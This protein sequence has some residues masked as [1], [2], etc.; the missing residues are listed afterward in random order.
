[1]ALFTED[2]LKKYA[3]AAV[4]ENGRK[5]F[6]RGK[7]TNLNFVGN[8]IIAQ[9]KADKPLKVVISRDESDLR[10]CCN[11][12]FSY[13]GACEHVVASMLAANEN[14]AIQIGINWDALPLEECDSTNE[15]NTPQCVN[16]DEYDNSADIDP[17]ENSG[18]DVEDIEPGKP[19]ARIYLTECDLML[20]AELRFAY[21]DGTVEFT[22]SDNNPV[23]M[24]AQQDG[25]IYRIHRSKVR[26]MTVVSRMHEFELVQ[27]QTGFF[28]PECDPRIWTLHELPRLA[29]EGFEIYGQDN[30]KTS[31]ARK[32]VP[33]LS[34]SIKSDSSG[35]DCSVEISYDG[36][37]AT[38]ASIIKAIRDGSKFVLLSDGTSG[39]LPQEW[40]DKFTSL[41]AAFDADPEEKS[42]KVKTSHVALAGML[43]DMA[44]I[45]KGDSE[46]I[47]KRGLFETFKGV[48]KCSLPKDF[49]ASMRP[50]QLAGYEWFY[51][52]KKFNF[53]GCLADDMGLGKTVQ[54]LA[55]LQKEKE[56]CAQ[57]P[58]LV[59]VPTSLLFNWQREAEKFAP[60]LQILCLHGASRNRYYDVAEM[61]DVILTSYGTVLRDIDILSKKQFHYIILDEAQVIKNPASRISR[62][63]RHL[64]S[65][66]R[67]A[68]SGTPI[69]NNLSEL[70]SLFS[71]LNPGML[72]TF[73]NFATNFIKP[74]EKEMNENA[75]EVL[76]RL[77]FPYILRRTKQQVA[78][79]LPPKNEIVLYAEML[80]KQK[81]V[82]DITREIFLG[83]IESSFQNEDSEKTRFKILEG[84]LR[85]RQIC[86]HPQM[87]DPSFSGDSGKFK[88]IE[89]SII[90]VTSGGHR[91]LVFSQFVK[92]LEI[93]KLRIAEK[94]IHSEILTGATS[95]R[96]AVVDRF[97]KKDG[98][99]VFFISLKAGGTGL[100]LTAADY[101]IHMDPWWNPSAENQASDRAYRIGQTRTV[102]VYKMITRNS[103]EER[104]LQMQDRKKKLMSS[105][106]HTEKTFFKQLTRDDILGMFT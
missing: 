70:W 88:L 55:F 99:P 24:I 58:T 56:S 97:Q 36:I 105:I 59:I 73:R 12:G 92:A 40:I 102:F 39:I 65:G 77:L 22:K 103:I 91:V 18:I 7:V 78:K 71:F 80:P 87:I 43:Y 11:C 4:V 29:A 79:E 47:E 25:R 44:D 13:G 61:A 86:C 84:M 28:T 64:R 101:V 90:D 62:A 42:L 20:L 3:F 60:S 27:Y 37:S 96:Q 15:K 67:I 68:L 51:F 81:T 33:K 17:D 85:L 48:E 94:G 57:H 6:A 35:F 54:T 34:V 31:N 98:A 89:D 49:I 46:F 53:N 50:Y 30:L 93:M 38:L 66:Y 95:D 45:R 69:E 1:M 100:N 5:C 76:R 75:A 14:Q 104:V 83:R 21:H 2:D 26:E 82:Y 23:R 10:F 9:V 8:D 72:G 52:L 19:V 106:I 41:F 16:E 63:L 32:T 74:I